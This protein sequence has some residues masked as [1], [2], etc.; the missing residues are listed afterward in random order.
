MTKKFTTKHKLLGFILMILGLMG[1]SSFNQTQAQ[2][3][4]EGYSY[5]G[6]AY[7]S[8][9]YFPI[10]RV[11]VKDVSGNYLLQKPADA[12]NQ[13]FITST[14][15][16]GNGYS[17]VS[18]KPSFSLSSGSKYTLETSASYGYI[19]YGGTYSVYI[20]C[21]IDLNRDGVF[22]S[23]EYM[24]NGWSQM[25][26]GGKEPFTGG[27]LTANTFTVP[28][29]VKAGTSR[30]RLMSSYSYQLNAN[31]P[32]PTGIS[33]SPTYYY[34]ETEDYTIDLANPTSLAA[35]FY[36][37]TSAFVGTPI[38]MTNNNQTGYIAHQWDIDDDGS[39]EY[40]TTNATHIFNSVGNRCVRLKSQNCLGRDSVLRCINI[41][42]PTS[43]P[44]VD[45]ASNT[46]EVERFGTVDFIDL[47]QNGPT[48]W[49]W[50]MFDPKDSVNTRID[51]ETYNNNLVGNDPYTNANP[52]VFFN[53]IGTYTVCLQTSNN[54]G[55]SSVLCKPNYIRVTPFK[56]NNLGAG[57]VQPIYEQSGN[58]IDDGGRT[59]NYSN[60][61]VD[62]ATIIPCGAKK[63]NL[64]FH[65]FKVASGDILRVY[66]GIDATGTP[67]H[68][69]N[70]FTAGNSPSLT[71]PIVATSGAL[72]V[73]FTSNGS[74]NDSGFIAS[75]TTERGPIVPP[76]ADFDIPDTLYN[77]NTYTFINTSLNALGKADFVW[78]IEPGYG[79]VAYTKDLEYAILT[80]NTY[81]VRLTVS[82]CM[83]TDYKIK[84][85]VVVTPHK[86]ADVD[87]VADNRRP[88]TGQTVNFEALNPK[89]NKAIKTNMYQWDFFPATISYVNSTTAND[90]KIS[91]TFNAKGKYTASLRAWNSL[92]SAA[93][94]VTVIKA[95]YI[96]AVEH[97]TP[98]LGVS[99]STDVAINEVILTDKDN[100]ELINNKSENNDL[101][102]DDYTNTNIKADLQYGST[103]E[104][105]ISRNTNVNPMTRKVWIDWNI[106]GD[107]IDAGEL[108][109]SEAA[110]TN[111]SFTAKFT[112]PDYTKAFEG[113][114]RMRIGASYSN[115]PNLPCGASS[116]VNNANRIGEFEDYTVVITNDNQPPVL[117]LNNDDTL[118]LEVGSTYTEYGA[119]ATD[120]TEGDISSK[121]VITSDLDMLFTGIYFLT[122]NVTD[123]GG[124]K[125]L[126][127]T[128][129]VYVVK[130]QT[131]PVLTLNGSDTVYLEVIKD[132]YVEDGATAMDNKDG[133][134]TNTILITGSVNT[135]MVGT[136]IVTYSVNDVAGNNASKQRVVI[137]RDTQKPVITNSDADASNNVK[138]QIVS[139]FIDRTSVT[140]NY[141]KPQLDVTPGVAGPVDT[142]FKGTYP[143]IYNATDGSGNMADTK[144][145]NYIV[146]DYVGPAINLNTLDTI[147]H[148][149]NKAY[150]PVQA[151]ASDNYYDNSQVSLTR[152]SNVDAYKLGLYYDEFV[153]TDGSGNK[154][155]RRRYVRVVDRVA[156]VINGYNLNV[157]LYSNIDAT[158]GV[159]VTD[160]YDSPQALRPRLEILIN[161][162]NTY[163]EGMYT[164]SFQVSDLSGNVSAPYQRLIWVSRLFPTITGDVK[165]IN[166]EKAINVYPNPTNGE[167][168]ISYNFATPEDVTIMVFNSTG[169]LVKSVNNVHGQSGIETIDL[170]NEANG[171]YHV[172]MM[173][174]GKQ[175]TRTISLNK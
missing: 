116:G 66:D 124:N 30:M 132:T 165:D 148:D 26:T 33:G 58:L 60:N 15:S 31:S 35:G 169:A 121:V 144:T 166:P 92:D 61:R 13:G 104:I 126:P 57:T 70:G 18:T 34:G 16:V 167:V 158:E 53:T 95:D 174:A 63:I 32:C 99:S 9:Y 1:S 139:V 19:G 125:A 120:P 75:W 145:Y 173:V 134:I 81:D 73:Y 2:S 27:P 135:N 161:N 82:T 79:E 8:Y 71:T 21:W 162:L 94:S 111:N 149:V 11:N 142:R 23:N 43:K 107:F 112:V 24:S 109:A 14:N 141:D 155:T 103:Y 130:D 41:V 108:V 163:E 93:T 146:D 42:N 54:L 25:N 67:L 4:C 10:E 47:S 128:R 72:Y 171:L 78:D 131:A 48:Y 105:M 138:V 84:K 50:Y 151:T 172:R 168:N 59:G 122:Y 175:I 56:D 39:I 38:K 150:T 22:S 90:P 55:P 100:V 51:V 119:T 29:G 74:G 118:Y 123:A 96:I 52:E 76:D 6:C 46:N 7:S 88:N 5:Y 115:D 37:P 106:D 69:G 64:Q 40:V 45:F 98:L 136:Y 110:G 140:D 49:S 44:I 62:Y 65:Q 156:P 157:G 85:V 91:V 102:Y 153:A 129:V 159:A 77:P 80:D 127:V 152:S 36:M 89:P 3:Y 143:M 68:T 170:S 28:C 160:N 113:K 137:V 20:Y 12:C 164:I 101:G 83:G 147:L 87:F 154:T 86:R 114:S 117:A 17:L 133:N 97:C